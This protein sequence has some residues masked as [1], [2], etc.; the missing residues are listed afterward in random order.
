MQRTI[1]GSSGIEVS[2]YC[3]GTMTYGTNTTEDEAYQ[4]LDLSLDHGI[5][6]LDTAEMYPVNPIKKETIGVTEEI[7]GRWNAKS[8]KRN[9]YVIATKCLGVN[10]SYAREGE[11]VNG[12]IIRSACESS[13]KRLQTDYIDL[14]QLHWPNRGSYHFR[15]IWN[16]D[17]SQQ[18]RATTIAHMEDVMSTLK[19]LVDEGKIRAFGL[20]NEST[21]GTDQWLSAAERTGGPRIESVQNEYSVLCRMP[22]DG[23]LAELCHNEMVTL[24]AFSPLATGFVTGKYLDGAIPKGSRIEIIGE[25]PRQSPRLDAA[26]RAFIDVAK[27][28]SV[29]PV[30]MAMAFCLQRPFPCIPIFGATTTSQLE[31]L[32]AGKDTK[33]TDDALTDLNQINRNHP[34]PF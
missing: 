28:H 18:D 24:L 30:H 14:Y 1:L 10:G 2:A 21:W 33:L 34:M 11:M 22:F 4:Q 29:D 27:K 19:A 31:H 6:F 26:V 7:I 23:D 17:P 8:G 3:L 5:D 32:Y 12:N 13:L 20:S 16:Y 9:Q 15:Q 25:S